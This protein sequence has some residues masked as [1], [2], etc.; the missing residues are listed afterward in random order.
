[1]ADFSASL[2]ASLLPQDR[3][4][5]STRNL[6]STCD[7]TSVSTADVGFIENHGTY[8]DDSRLDHV[9]NAAIFSGMELANVP[10]SLSISR[11]VGIEL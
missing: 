1:M 5:A 7:S 10:D 9:A 11:K 2:D 6:Q 4:G 8:R 3:I